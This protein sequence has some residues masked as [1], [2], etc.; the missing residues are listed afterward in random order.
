ML[1]GATYHTRLWCVMELFTFLQMGGSSER[2]TVRELHEGARSELAAFD[3]S[4]ASCFLRKDKHKLLA[5]IEEGFG[6][7]RPFNRVVRTILAERVGKR[8]VT[9]QAEAAPSRSPKV[10]PEPP[11]SRVLSAASARYQ[12]AVEEYAVQDLTAGEA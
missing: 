9:L 8:S 12:V 2:I 3:A 11:S 4:K 6:D 5:V 1:A 7:L 10:A